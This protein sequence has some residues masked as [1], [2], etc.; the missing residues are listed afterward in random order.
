VSPGFW[1]ADESSPRLTRDLD[2]WTVDLRSM[3][4]SAAPWQLITTW[5]E[6]GEGT[7][8]EDAAEWSGPGAYGAYI[9]AMHD[10]LGP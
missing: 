1:K 6:W 7:A 4:A 10:T 9:E 2:R 5:N 8:V 3:V